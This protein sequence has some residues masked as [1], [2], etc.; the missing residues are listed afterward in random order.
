MPGRARRRAAGLCTVLV[1]GL[2]A[3]PA[4]QGRA[5]VP[6]NSELLLK[7]TDGSA[8]L[9]TAVLQ[10]FG[11]VELEGTPLMKQRGWV[12]VKVPLLQPVL[13]VL[14]LLRL[15]LRVQDAVPNLPLV[16]TDAGE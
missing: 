15:D 1:L 7:L 14:K 6:G 8:G 11:L 4:S 9:L 5:E 3:L 16:G 12:R 2:L 10:L 13:G